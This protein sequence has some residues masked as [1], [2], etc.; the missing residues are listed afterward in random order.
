MTFLFM[1]QISPEDILMGVPSIS[2]EISPSSMKESSFV[3][4]SG[5]PD[6][7]I[8][9]ADDKTFFLYILIWIRC[10]NVVFICMHGEF[11]GF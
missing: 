9:W 10:D 5:N 11:S 7:S 1:R 3:T 2:I 8:F 6:I 4:M